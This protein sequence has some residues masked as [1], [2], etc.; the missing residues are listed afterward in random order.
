VKQIR[1]EGDSGETWGMSDSNLLI[2]PLPPGWNNHQFGDACDRVKDSYQPVDDGDTPYVALSILPRVSRIRW[3]RK[4]ERVRSSKTASSRRH[5][6]RETSSL[7]SQRRTSR[8]RWSLLNGHLAFRAK[9]T[10][11]SEFLKFIIHSDEFVAHAKST[12]CGV[13]HPRTSWPSLREFRFRSPAPRAEEDRAHPFDGAA[14]DRSP[15]ADHS[16]HHR[17]EKGPHA[18]ALHRR[19]PQRT[20]KNKPKSARPRKL[21]G[22]ETP[23]STF[24]LLTLCLKGEFFVSDGPTVL[25]PGNFKL[26]G[27]SIGENAPNTRPKVT[28][29][30]WF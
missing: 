13:Q 10:C 14:G 11:E 4:R 7:S 22:G 6:L 9:A 15:G 16:D 27:A 25:T 3:P 30:T 28:S 18:Q 29:K 8:L 24:R 2:E 1:L 12:T 21:G 26:D 5:T 20:P 23:A 19:P 17:A